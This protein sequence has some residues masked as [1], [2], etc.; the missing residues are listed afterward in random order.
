MIFLTKGDFPSAGRLLSSRDDL[1][2]PSTFSSPEEQNNPTSN[3]YRY[4]VVGIIPAIFIDEDLPV[5]KSSSH[6]MLGINALHST[7]VSSDDELCHG[8][9]RPEFIE[10]KISALIRPFLGPATLIPLAKN[11]A[12]GKRQNNADGED[13]VIDDNHEEG[14]MKIIN[15]GHCHRHG[16]DAV[17]I[18]IL[19]KSQTN[20]SNRSKRAKRLSDLSRTCSHSLAHRFAS[21]IDAVR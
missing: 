1:D 4:L 13:I 15:V 10:T 5:E 19:V 8:Y 2:I 7:I 21:M 17:S 16:R 20:T 6:Q 11:W 9:P 12:T 18:R 14:E 3:Q